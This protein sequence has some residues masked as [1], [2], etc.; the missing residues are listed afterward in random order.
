VSIGR[1]LAA[2]GLGSV[3]LAATVIG[4]GIEAE[5]L[6]SGNTA[7]ALLANTAATVA[8][9]AVLIALLAPVSGAHFNPA[10]TLIQA[11]RRTLTWQQ[12]A[13]YTLVQIV[14]CSLGAILAHVMF[15]LPWLQASAHALAVRGRVGRTVGLAG[16]LPTGCCS[17]VYRN[18]VTRTRVYC[19]GDDDASSSIRLAHLTLA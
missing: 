18:S 1:R 6:A 14:G 11:I 8:V 12:A 16:D 19:A 15:E 7:I 5:R 3:L 10:A 4:S 2:E 13:A 17:S 9:L